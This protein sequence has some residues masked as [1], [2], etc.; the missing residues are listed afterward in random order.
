MESLAG[1]QWHSISAEDALRLLETS[2]EQGLGEEQVRERQKRF[3]KNVLPEE[4]Y[5]SKIEVFLSQF[6]N[7]L[8]FILLF[9]S[10]IT[11][12][13][14]HLKDSA[15]IFSAVLLN[16]FIGYFEEYKA[17]RA[18]AELKLA[19]SQRARVLRQGNKKEIPQ[20]GLVLGDIIFLA[21]GD[22]VPADG[23]IVKSWGLK[24]QE[25]VLTGEWL[26]SEKTQGVLEEKTPL[27]DRDNLVYMGSL[28]EEG[29]GVAV[30]VAT[31]N[32]TEIGKIAVLIKKIRSEISPY[33]ARI[34]R[35]SHVIGRVVG[36][37]VILIFLEGLLAKR[38][39][40]EM[41]LTG[42]AVA[43]GAIPEGLPIAITAILAVGMRRILKRGGLVKNLSSAET[44]GS[45]TVI[46]TD[47]TLTLTE[48]TMAVEDIWTLEEQQKTEA[49]TIAALVSEGRG[50]THIAL[51]KAALEAGVLRHEL[52]EAMQLVQKIPFDSQQKYSATFYKTGEGI[53][54]YV[55]GAPETLFAF[56]GLSQDQ[57]HPCHA[58]LQ[59]LA[60]RGL[61]VLAVG[62]SQTVTLQKNLTFV[63]LIAL[64]DPLRK[65]AQEA[66]Q[67]AKEAGVRTIMVT[68][69]HLLT[70]KAVAK[71][72][73]IEEGDVYAR[74]DPAEKLRIVEE[75][76]A[77]GEIIAMTGDGVND[78]PALK[79]ADIGIALGSGTD[80]AKEA[81]DLILLKDQ[82][83]IIP[84][85][86]EEG[87]IIA[88]NIRKV[89]TYM[90]SGTFTETILIG[91][92]I[93]LGWP[94]PVTALQILWVNLVEDGLPGIALTFEKGE[95]DVMKRRPEGK[96][97]SLLT[98]SMKVI[99]FAVSI[100]S[101]ILLLGL[102]GWLFAN[103]SYSLD[104]I[105]TV[106]FVGLA[107]NS[108]LYIF[109][110]KSMRKNL[111]QYN[112]FT[113]HYLTGSVVLGMFLLALVVYIPFLQDIFHTTVLA[114]VDW[115][116]LLV[117]GII[118]VVLIEITKWYFI[119]KTDTIKV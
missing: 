70:A 18:L 42:V 113:N 43:V 3:G 85:A 28:I 111:W 1:K 74:V 44:L 63:G 34:L 96:A 117:L 39:V 24:I 67:L 14:G 17:T 79:K 13:I 114:G 106:V 19:L 107:L 118:N 115:V 103:S 89:I 84:A 29:E 6:K 36:A 59:E 41:F 90:L 91:A 82:F 40:L 94:L 20:E 31:G 55:L 46:A 72:L 86:I 45:T 32:K 8:I 76:Q 68:G 57:T 2:V 52:K 93:L 88:D 48:G 11:F 51:L 101:D 10:I 119:R 102:F 35:F 77:K 7:P 66:V 97:I 87:R 23:R 69:D 30:V 4:K 27:A 71:E 110:C 109:S 81:A 47:K 16:S 25:A 100:F 33:Q 104:H 116:I 105:R 21:P 58:K 95:K 61:R 54:G 83:S 38:E 99:I 80:V 98:P 56:S 78:A 75:W 22:K 65:G 37:L 112:P 5:A 92:S 26:A 62:E 60:Q 64:K 73:G 9:A 50:P 108:L 53:R 12:L 49:L 15:V